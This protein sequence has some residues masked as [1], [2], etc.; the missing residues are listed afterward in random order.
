MNVHTK[1][2]CKKG[3]QFRLFYS[4]VI[5]KRFGPIKSVTENQIN[6]PKVIVLQ[7]GIKE[8]I[9]LEVG[10]QYVRK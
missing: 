7:Y 4:A 1:K 6:N 3:I 9:V 5:N 8:K 10:K 2:L